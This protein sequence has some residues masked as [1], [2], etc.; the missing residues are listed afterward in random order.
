LSENATL[1]HAAAFCDTQPVSDRCV[2]HHA[3]VEPDGYADRHANRYTD[4][5]ADVDA[6]ANRYSDPN[7]NSNAHGIAGNRFG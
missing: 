6:D 5:H 7:A 3:D 1:A 4:P 2:D